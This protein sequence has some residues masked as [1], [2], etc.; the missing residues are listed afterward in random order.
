MS[1]SEG[2]LTDGLKEEILA[3]YGEHFGWR[4]IESLRLP[5]R[6]T[7]AIGAGNYVNLG[8]RRADGLSRL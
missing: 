5:D 6:I 7:I 3:F 8:A 2:T 1:V 4:E